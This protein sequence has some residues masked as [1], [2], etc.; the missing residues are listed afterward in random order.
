MAGE[1][2]VDAGEDVSRFAAVLIA[3][4]LVGEPL[5]VAG[6]A[7]VVDHQRRPALR[8]VDLRLGAK[9]GPCWPCGPPWIMTTSGCFEVA[10]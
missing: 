5:A 9:A 8:R 2:R 4:D 10:V 3:E 6:G 1:R 7:A